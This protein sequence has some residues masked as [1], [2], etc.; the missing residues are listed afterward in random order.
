MKHLPLQLS[1]FTVLLVRRLGI[2]TLSKGQV[3]LLYNYIRGEEGADIPYQKFLD[4][5]LNL[6]RDYLGDLHPYTYF[7]SCS[8]IIDITYSSSS[9]EED[10]LRSSGYVVI[11]KD[12]MEIDN[13]MSR[14]KT[15]G[16][17]NKKIW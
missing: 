4:T 17:E 12:N 15:F 3:T 9:K 16:T 11:K 10:N 5:I 14:K 13:Y 8:C 6:S 1:S 2:S 7:Y